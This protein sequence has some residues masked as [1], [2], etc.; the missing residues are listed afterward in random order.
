MLRWVIAI[1]NPFGLGGLFGDMVLGS[2]I[3][4]FSIKSCWSKFINVN[5]IYTFGKYYFFCSL[6][7]FFELKKTGGIFFT[8]LSF[9]FKA[10]SKLLSFTVGFIALSITRT[11]IFN[12]STK[13]VAGIDE[14]I[15]RTHRGASFEKTYADVIPK[16]PKA[17][18]RL[19]STLSHIFLRTPTDSGLSKIEPKISN[20][21]SE[22]RSNRL[23]SKIS[24]IIESRK[25]VQEKPNR[26]E[27]KERL[28]AGIDEIEVCFLR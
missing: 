18:S 19:K 23:S 22:V 8:F 17:S 12:Q 21:Q 11:K 26:E 3:N 13:E 15:E 2:I 4:V 28:V 25:E 5:F 16:T 7:H 6:Y 14:N 20:T 10:S 9:I 24:S 27:M 1:G